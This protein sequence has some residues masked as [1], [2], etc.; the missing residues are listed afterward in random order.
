[1]YKIVGADQ[2]EY[3]PVTEEQ[4]RQ[5]IA[6]GRANGQTIARLGDGPW[7][8]LA[9][10]PE[11]ASALGAP[12]VG[13]G[14]IGA[15]LPP[16]SSYAGTATTAVPV[17]NGL[18]IGGLICSILGLLCCGPVFSTLGLVLSVIGL[19]QIKDHP[20]RYTGRGMALAGIILA[21][22]GYA[23]FA[24]LVFT[25]ILRRAFRRFPRYI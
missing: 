15:P 6:E 11:F 3:G 17:T 14:L 18:A 13:S 10:F 4:L 24:F 7:K 23:F 5:W 8:P 25:G 21:V 1:M 20:A 22:I 16:L 9:T 12:P 19:A 2:K